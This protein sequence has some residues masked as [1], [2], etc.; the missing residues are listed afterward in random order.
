MEVRDGKGKVLFS[1][2]NAPGSTQVVDGEGAMSLIVGNANGV[3]L[4]Y[5]GKPVDLQPHIK[6]MVARL[7][8]E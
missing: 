5:A 7:K 1:K 3:T 4:N 8:V 2:L 6:G